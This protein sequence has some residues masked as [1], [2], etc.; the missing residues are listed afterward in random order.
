MVIASQQPAV[1]GRMPIAPCGVGATPAMTIR[2]DETLPSGRGMAII[3]AGRGTISQS[4][5]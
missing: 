3:Q 1:A 4:A 5:R 2:A